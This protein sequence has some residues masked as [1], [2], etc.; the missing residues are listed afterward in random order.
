MIKIKNF[1]NVNGK[2][3]ANGYHRVH[4]RG[5]AGKIF[6]LRRNVGEKDS[7]KELSGISTF[8]KI[9]CALSKNDKGSVE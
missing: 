7:W 4:T 8:L 9:I 5:S 6:S 1:H 2:L 3:C